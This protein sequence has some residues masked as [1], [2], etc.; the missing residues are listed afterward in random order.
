MFG[1]GVPVAAQS[2]VR[3][4]PSLMVLILGGELVN[5]G[6]TTRKKMMKMI[7]SDVTTVPYLNP[8]DVWCW[9]ATEL[10]NNQL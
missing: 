9:S 6:V 2:R 4:C 3:S 8:D 7:F 5:F 1:A 10:L